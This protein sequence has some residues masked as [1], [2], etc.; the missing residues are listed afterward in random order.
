MK[1]VLF[2][3]LALTLVLV[4][5]GTSPTKFNDALVKANTVISDVAAKY[6]DDLS[7]AIDNDS[8]ADIATMTDSALVKIDAELSV[9][10]GLEAPKGGDAFKEAAVKS[11][12][13]L[14]TVVETGKKFATLTAE[15]TQEE[16]SVI[17]KE[18][19]EQLDA[20]SKT[21]D[22]LSKAQMDYAKE[23]GYK[24]Q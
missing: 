23:A 24:V 13:S 16:Y 10:K 22:A 9:V 17:E 6:Q 14:R 15:S 21:F 19:N 11:Y 4:S 2:S 20:Y 7:K 1:K 3:L 8:Y 12:E 18:Y 5:C